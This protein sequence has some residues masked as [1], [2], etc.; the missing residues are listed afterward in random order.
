MEDTAQQCKDNEEGVGLAWH[1]CTQSLLEGLACGLAFMAAPMSHPE[2]RAL[3]LGCVR[4]WH[5]ACCIASI[6]L[7]AALMQALKRSPCTSLF[8]FQVGMPL[9]HLCGPKHWLTD[10]LLVLAPLNVPQLGIGCG[11]ASLHL[12]GWSSLKFFAMR[13]GAAADSWRVRGISH[14]KAYSA[15]SRAQRRFARQRLHKL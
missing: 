6:C 5:E 7:Q 11:P 14:R 3:E 1:P 4:T 10:L 12:P 9:R 15:G 2:L 8:Q 13:V